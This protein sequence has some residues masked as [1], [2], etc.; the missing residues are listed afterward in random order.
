MHSEIKKDSIS[1]KENNKQTQLPKLP[2]LKPL[3]EVRDPKPVEVG[4]CWC[5]GIGQ[6]VVTGTTFPILLGR[7]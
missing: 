3:E 2:N 5:P 7:C 1:A 6:E 4:A